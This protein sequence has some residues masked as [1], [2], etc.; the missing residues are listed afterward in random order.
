MFKSDI[1]IMLGSNKYCFKNNKVINRKYIFDSSPIEPNNDYFK[2]LNNVELRKVMYESQMKMIE[3]EL[4]PFGFYDDGSSFM[5]NDDNPVML[6]N[7]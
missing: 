5:A 3:E 6:L 7:F 1:P 4:T 2:E